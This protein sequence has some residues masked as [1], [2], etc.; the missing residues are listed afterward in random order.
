MSGMLLRFVYVVPLTLL[1]YQLYQYRTSEGDVD[2]AERFRQDVFAVDLQLGPEWEM[3][4]CA[5]DLPVP[6][7]A[8]V[9]HTIRTS[10]SCL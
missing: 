6:A 1:L 7:S 10:A 8:I 4:F 3:S 5:E 2:F 9:L